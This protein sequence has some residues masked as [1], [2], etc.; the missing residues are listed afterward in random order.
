V[1]QLSETAGP[2]WCRATWTG[3]ALIAQTGQVA[4]ISYLG[5]TFVNQVWR[6]PPRPGE[7]AAD[8]QQIA[9][10]YCARLG[11]THVIAVLDAEGRSGRSG[12]VSRQPLPR[13]PMLGGSLRRLPIVDQVLSTPRL[14]RAPDPAGRAFASSGWLPRLNP[15]G[16]T[17]AAPQPFDLREGGRPGPDIYD[18]SWAERRGRGAVLWRTC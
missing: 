11:R 5:M 7:T 13:A 14:K 8:R 16:Y 17:Q 2:I 3:Q 9:T 6:L 4:A 1:M 18:R 12:G 15:S 10:D